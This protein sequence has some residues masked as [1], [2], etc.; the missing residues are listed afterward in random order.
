MDVPARW[1]GIGLGLA[2]A[3]LLAIAHPHAHPA[4][5]L[6]LSVTPKVTTAPAT[7]KV[8]AL[9]DRNAG[10][11]ELV[12]EADSGEYFRSSAIQLD[13]ADAAISYE[14]WFRSLPPGEYAITAF[15][16]DDHG[17]MTRATT[18]AR[19]LGSTDTDR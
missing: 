1:T 14:V 3:I 2:T 17:K 16:E 4:E 5:T 8:I 12:V 19:I 13:G 6:R 15:V 9:I 18:T 7:V 11:R 10:N